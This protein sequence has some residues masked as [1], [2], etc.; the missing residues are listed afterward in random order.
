MDIINSLSETVEI[1]SQLYSDSESENINIISESEYNYYDVRHGTECHFNNSGEREEYEKKYSR[2]EIEK[3]NEYFLDYIKN[4]NNTG[5]AN[6][7]KSFLNYLNDLNYTE[8]MKIEN[9]Y[10][11]DDND[12][13]CPCPDCLKNLANI[14][15]C[16]AP[17]IE[18]HEYN[19]YVYF[20]DCHNLNDFRKRIEHNVSVLNNCPHHRRNIN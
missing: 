17:R 10:Y 3:Y 18:C 2:T 11:N 1:H 13:L 9:E 12:L 5:V 19:Q 14:I 4:F 8:K 16:Y 20:N 7:I 15:T 6:N